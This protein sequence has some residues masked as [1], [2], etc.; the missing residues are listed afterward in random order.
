VWGR[1]QGDLYKNGVAV[2]SDKLY[3]NIRQKRGIMTTFHRL[4][5]PRWN[6]VLKNTSISLQMIV[7]IECI[8][9]SKLEFDR[10]NG[11]NTTDLTFNYDYKLFPQ[12]LFHTFR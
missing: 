8:M 5:N 9:T 7:A 10:F 1:E 2:A 4:M 12:E 6:N 11:I 3:G